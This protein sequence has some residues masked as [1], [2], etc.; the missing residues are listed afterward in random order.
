LGR[1]EFIV[2]LPT[3]A[4]RLIEPDFV[5]LIEHVATLEFPNIGQ[6]TLSVGLSQLFP[7]DEPQQILERAGLALSKAQSQNTKITPRPG[8]R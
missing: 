1:E 5:S 8:A 4:T 6:V 2:L 7:Q 3:T